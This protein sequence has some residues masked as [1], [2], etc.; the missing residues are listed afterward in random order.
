MNIFSRN[1]QLW[2]DNLGHFFRLHT[3]YFLEDKMDLCKMSESIQSRLCEQNI[4]PLR[5]HLV[6]PQKLKM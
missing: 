3:S 4:V 2:Q 6:L 1:L 5:N